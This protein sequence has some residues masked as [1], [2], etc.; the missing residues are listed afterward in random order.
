V[1]SAADLTRRLQDAGQY[2]DKYMAA[3]VDD[4]ARSFPDLTDAHFVRA[5]QGGECDATCQTRTDEVRRILEGNWPRV[6]SPPVPPQQP[7]AGRARRQ[8]GNVRVEKLGQSYLLYCSPEGLEEQPGYHRLC[9][10]CRSIGELPDTYFP[11]YLNEVRCSKTSCVKEHG[12]CVQKYL[13]LDILRNDGTNEC[14]RWVQYTASVPV[15]CDCMLA[16]Q[17]TVFLSLVLKE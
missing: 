2:N 9:A 7:T 5:A 11:R 16:S 13:N 1:L 4:A 17:S 14:Q 8:A 10:G 15:C 3:T 6:S 12:S